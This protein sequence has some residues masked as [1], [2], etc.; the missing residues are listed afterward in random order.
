MQMMSAGG[1]TLSHSELRVVGTQSPK[2]SW[3]NGRGKQVTEN[4]KPT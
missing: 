4:E 2:R 1:H 3:S